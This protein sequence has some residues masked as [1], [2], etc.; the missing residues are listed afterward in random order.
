[1]NHEVVLRSNQIDRGEAAA[2]P[3]CA[4][5]ERV[6]HYCADN[7]RPSGPVRTMVGMMLLKSIYNPSDEVAEDKMRELAIPMIFLAKPQVLTIFIL[8]LCPGPGARRGLQHGSWIGAR[9]L[10]G[11]I[12]PIRTLPDSPCPQ[13]RERKIRPRRWTF[14]RMTSSSTRPTNIE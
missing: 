3:E 11:P 10:R 6:E 4:E 12:L 1:M 14:R 8:V 5:H 13:A 2:E 9:L 7:G